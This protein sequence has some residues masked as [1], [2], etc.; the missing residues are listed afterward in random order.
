MLSRELAVA[1]QAFTHE[2]PTANNDGA[3]N[4]IL[5]A[6]DKL[7]MLLVRRLFQRLSANIFL[8]QFNFPINVQC[9]PL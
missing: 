4:K 6:A 5:V 1:L 7:I 3:V 9:D 2:I 8:L